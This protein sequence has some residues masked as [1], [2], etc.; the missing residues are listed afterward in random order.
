MLLLL[1]SCG[2]AWL[3]GFA[4]NLLRL[5]PAAAALL[6]DGCARRTLR[7]ALAVSA[8]VRTAQLPGLRLGAD[9]RHVED[10]ADG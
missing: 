3:H 8:T 2:R 1:A 10:S 7:P 6:L 5:I 4:L 9:V